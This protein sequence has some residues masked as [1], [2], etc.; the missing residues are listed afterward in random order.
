MAQ[1]SALK[2]TQAYDAVKQE[3]L[4]GKLAPGEWIDV[5]SLADTLDI[6]VTTVRLALY[7]LAG[8]E[9]VEGHPRQGFFMRPLTESNLQDLF[10]IRE[11]LQIL[12]IRSARLGSSTNLRAALYRPDPNPVTAIDRLFREIA[13]FSGHDELSQWID[14]A[15][16]RLAFLRQIKVEMLPNLQDAQEK[17]AGFWITGDLSNLEGS[18]RDLGDRRRQHVPDFVTRLR[19][20]Q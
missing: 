18:L 3:V 4:S 10:N 15:S 20:G 7:R 9:L 19:T 1:P 5:N 14:R 13:I 8:E 6:S 2:A 11:E 17:I 16:N 12:V